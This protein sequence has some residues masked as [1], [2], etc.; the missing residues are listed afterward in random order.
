MCISVSFCDVLQTCSSL[1]FD[2]EICSSQP[3]VLKD[4]QFAISY[5]ARKVMKKRKFSTRLLVAS[6]DELK[7]GRRCVKKYL[8]IWS[9]KGLSVCFSFLVVFFFPYISG[10]G[11]CAIH[12]KQSNYLFSVVHFMFS[13]KTLNYDK[14]KKEKFS[15]A[16]WELSL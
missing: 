11:Q 9:F 1:G 3:N 7:R 13:T 8:A 15:S 10:C 2:A 14:E 12:V 4:F 6:L 5:H 16:I